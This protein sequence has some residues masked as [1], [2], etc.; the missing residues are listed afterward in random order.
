ME[1]GD[2]NSAIAIAMAVVSV[3]AIAVVPLSHGEFRKLEGFVYQYP[4]YISGQH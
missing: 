3:A 1:D 4:W 2:F